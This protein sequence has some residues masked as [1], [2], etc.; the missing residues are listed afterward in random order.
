MFA[1]NFLKEQDVAGI[2]VHLFASPATW[3]AQDDH[4]ESIP[5]VDLLTGQYNYSC[6]ANSVWNILPLLLFSVNLNWTP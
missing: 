1:E 5:Q 3:T 2:R 4:S 6:Y